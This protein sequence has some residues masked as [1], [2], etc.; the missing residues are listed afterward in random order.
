[1]DAH[2]WDDLYYFG[3]K[4]RGDVFEFFYVVSVR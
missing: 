3:Y 1:M 4:K 2:N